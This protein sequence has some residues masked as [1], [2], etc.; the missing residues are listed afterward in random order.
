[1][2]APKLKKKEINMDEISKK[3]KKQRRESRKLSIDQIVG[4]EREKKKKIRKNN[5]KARKDL[6][7][8]NNFIWVRLL[9]P[10][11]K[12][13][14]TQQ[15]VMSNKK[16]STAIDNEKKNVMNLFKALATDSK[17]IFYATH[18]ITKTII[19]KQRTHYIKK[20]LFL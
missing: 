11:K 2:K 10:G 18:K 13:R 3:P 17:S 20:P 8:F 19:K 6:V 5:K 12:D 4:R 14:L 1:M 9:N 7:D 16:S 15:L